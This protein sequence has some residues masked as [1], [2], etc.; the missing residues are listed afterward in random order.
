MSKKSTNP[1]VKKSNNPF[2]GLKG[3]QF[4]GKSNYCQLEIGERLD[5]VIHAGIEKKV[6]LGS[7]ND[8][9]NI[10]LG[11]IPGGDGQPIRMMAAAIFR[12]NIEKAKLKNGDIYSVAR[13]P[14]AKK[15]SGKGKG[16]EMEVYAILVTKRK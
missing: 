11:I 13:M 15:K 16:K 9:V 7:G 4:G 1:N 2:E 12:N 14:N 10:P 3:E 6:D 8:P 5:G